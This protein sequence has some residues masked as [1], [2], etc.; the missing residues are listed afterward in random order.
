MPEKLRSFFFSR[1]TVIIAHECRLG[2]PEKLRGVFF[3]RRFFRATL[4]SLRVGNARACLRCEELLCL[5]VMLVSRSDTWAG[6]G[7][8]CHPVTSLVRHRRYRQAQVSLARTSVLE[9][10]A[11]L[12]GTVTLRPSRRLRLRNHRQAQE[13]QIAQGH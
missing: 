3:A 13:L 6:Q 10:R 12:R 7:R 8:R 5:P 4:G 2:M 9:N 11:S 1:D